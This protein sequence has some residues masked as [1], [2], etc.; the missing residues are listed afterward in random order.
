MPDHKVL[1]IEDEVAI[2][3]ALDVRLSAMGYQTMATH[4]A[5]SG[6]CAATTFRPD[7]LILDIRLPDLDGIEVCHRL[8][9]DPNLAG[10]QVILLSAN[11]TDVSRGDAEDAGAVACLAKPYE[12]QDVVAAIESAA[13]PNVSEA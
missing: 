9:E 11:I 12:I 10:I 4:D 1:I 3:T 7:V 2:A 13:S 5:R 8:K 6:L